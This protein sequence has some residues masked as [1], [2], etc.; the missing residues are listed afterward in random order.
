MDNKDD[1]DNKD[2]FIPLIIHQVWLQGKE[3][4][5]EKFK[6]NVEKIKEKHPSPKWKY[7][8]WDEKSFLEDFK[9]EK[10]NK[11]IEKYNKFVYLHQKVDFLKICVL[12]KYGGI[13]LDIDNEILKSLDELINKNNNYDLIISMVNSNSFE[14]YLICNN[15]KGCANNGNIIAKKNAPIL[16]YMLD[17]FNEKECSSLSL[18]VFCISNTTGPTIFNKLVN[19]YIND[20]KDYKSKVLFLENYYLE[21]CVFNKCEINENTIVVH[22]HELS[23]INGFFKF[24]IHYYINNK[25]LFFLTLIVMLVTISYITYKITYKLPS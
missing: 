2:N 21:P 5:P 8:I 17:N 15:T 12:T 20:N 19:Q 6:P 11:Y 4:I 23:W 24:I 9:G 3:L 7:I 14:N 16:N 18:K 25:I 13:F 1:K 10:Y 22:K